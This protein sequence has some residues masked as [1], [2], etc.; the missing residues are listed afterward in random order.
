MTRFH[1]RFHAVVFLIALA[2]AANLLAQDQIPQPQHRAKAEVKYVS[3]ESLGNGVTL[4]TMTN[5]LTVIVR[6]N[7]AAPVATVRTFVRNTGSAYEG[8]DFLGAG[9]SHVLEHLVSGGS[10]RR[11]TE[12]EIRAIVDS[13]GGQT[14]AYTSN[15]LTSYHIDC[16]ATRVNE[17]I[18]L[19]ADAMQ[20]VVFAEEEY[21]RELGVVQ[22]ELEMGEADRDRMMY[23]TMKR[24]VYT[25]H[26]IRIPTV[27]YLQVLQG[28]ARQDIIDFYHQR[29]VPQD[30]IFVVVGDVDTDKVLAEVLDGFQGVRR[31]IDPP[32]LLEQEPQQASPREVRLEMP[33]ATTKFAIAWPTVALQ[34]PDLYPLDVASY[35]LTHGDSSRITKRLTVDEPLAVSVDSSSYTPGFVEGWFEVQVEC[36][37]GNV[38]KCARVIIEEVSRLKRDLVDEKELAKVK[39]QK[40][41]EH[42]FSQQTVQDQAESLGRSYLSTN[43]P[44]FDDQYVK[45]IQR[46]TPEQI[47]TAARRYFRPE[48][49]NTV[50]ISPIGSKL[51]EAGGG[52]LAAAESEVMKKLLPNGLT[53]LVKRHA[54]QPLVTMQ[55][56]VK[57]GIIS[58]TDAKSGRAALSTA[59]M[60]K[61]TQ[62]Y[63][64]EQIAQYFDSIGG[65]L[66]VASQRNSSYLTCATLA[67]D[68]PTAFDYCHQVLFRP[69]FPEGEFKKQQQQQLTRISARKGN[70]QAEVLDFWTT[71]LPESTPFHRTV[72]GRID[73]VS[74]LT[75]ADAKEFHR[76]YFAPNNM[77]LAIYG[78]I[79]PK[80]T[81]ARVEATFGREPKNDL[82]FPTFKDEHFSAKPQTAVLKNQQQ[83]TSMVLMSYPSVSVYAEKEREAL[84]VLGGVLTGGGSGR[85]FEELRGARLVYYVFGFEMTG[86]APGYYLFMAQTRP[87]TA[88]E[89]VERISANVE[90]VRKEG[91]PKD[92]LGNAKGRLIAAHALKDTTPGEQAFQAAL[93]ELY[94]LGYDYDKTYDE[95]ISRVTSDDIQAVVAKYFRNPL[96][97]TTQPEAAE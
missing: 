57:A 26:P 50:T 65:G 28:V 31:G 7:H 66:S 30:I 61:G 46:V 40:A 24:L 55:V 74:K 23:N 4:A 25:K 75:V 68:F 1:G 14:N 73:T 43:D 20:N 12:A 97:I 13:M 85:L 53:V 44:L 47:Q 59:V 88:S 84:E 6:E 45:G 92:E 5:G 21:A 80:E 83:G 78:D 3:R 79:D 90:K 56:F 35:L 91:I 17:A 60:D 15:D 64:A 42:V 39:R 34:D 10:T 27:G 86:L 82:K 36:E 76:T 62:K 18:A 94:G 72:E 96:V 95:R 54:V 63:T 70:P 38:E 87:E 9:L 19:T 51:G 33:G 81:M 22:R 49:E 58:D 69:T 16:P 89:V 41:A 48:K 67:D 37:P 93:N 32:P 71:K 8:P 11:R 2:G 77:V 52:A 29:Y